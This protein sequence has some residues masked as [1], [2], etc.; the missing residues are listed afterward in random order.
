MSNRIVPDSKVDGSLA[1]LRDSAAD[2]K[3]ATKE[4]LLAER[5]VK[6]VEALLS[7]ASDATSDSKRLADARTSQQWLDAIEDEAEKV[8]ELAKLKALREA[9]SANIE[10]WRSEQANYRAMKI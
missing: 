8:G 7:K 5:W 3:K 2:L 1:F 10:A 6:H 9:A 4:A